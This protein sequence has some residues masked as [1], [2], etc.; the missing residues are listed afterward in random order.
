MAFKRPIIEQ[1]IQ[2]FFPASL[3]AKGLQKHLTRSFSVHKYQKKPDERILL[4]EIETQDL[5]LFA[6]RKAEA[7]AM[8]EKLQEEISQLQIKHSELEELSQS[9]DHLHLLQ[10]NQHNSYHVYLLTH[11]LLAPTFT[12]FN[13][14]CKEAI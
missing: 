6:G 10:V 2:S 1:V 8:I 12:L 11:L 5:S 13:K 3:P 4:H 14:S 7:M 9:D